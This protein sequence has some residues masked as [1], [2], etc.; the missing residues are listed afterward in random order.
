MAK[1]F[2]KA[3]DAKQ[4]MPTMAP[5]SMTMNQSPKLLN[6]SMAVPVKKKVKP[7][8]RGKK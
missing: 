5:Q 8:R 6:T 2:V 1:K 4:Q 7:V 3:C